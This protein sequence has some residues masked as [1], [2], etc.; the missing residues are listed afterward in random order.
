MAPSIMTLGALRAKTA[1][2]LYYSFGSALLKKYATNLTS[3]SPA[4]VPTGV[5]D[6]CK[7]RLLSLK[8]RCHGNEFS[9]F[10]YIFR[11]IWMLFCSA[12]SPFVQFV[13]YGHVID[14]FRIVKLLRI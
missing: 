11:L 7:I 13:V 1:S 3:F 4:G 6:C 9:S 12:Q 10:L 8:G 5:D 2:G 14:S